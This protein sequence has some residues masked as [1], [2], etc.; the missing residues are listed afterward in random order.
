MV[1]KHGIAVSCMQQDSCSDIR[2]VRIVA[3]QLGENFQCPGIETIAFQVV[4]NS[5]ILE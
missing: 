4:G 3:K 5:Q 2:I 1:L